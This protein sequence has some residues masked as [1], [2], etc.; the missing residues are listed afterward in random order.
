AERLCRRVAIIRGGAL[1]AVGTPDELRRRFAAAPEASLED[2]FLRATDPNAPNA[3]NAPNSPNSPNT[4]STPNTPNSPGTPGTPGTPFLLPLLMAAA[5]AWHLPAP[6][7]LVALATTTLAQSAI[8]A[9]A[10]AI[11]VAVV[12]WV[13]RRRRTALFVLLRLFAALTM[14]AAWVAATWV[15]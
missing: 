11:Q 3:P 15:L 14:A 9:S 13:P 5:F 2:L 10:Q 1:Q 12:R 7:G 6:V 8:A 4:A